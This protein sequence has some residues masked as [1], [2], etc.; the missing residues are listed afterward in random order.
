MPRQAGRPSRVVWLAHL[1]L[2]SWLIRV[3]NAVLLAPTHAG[4]DS[5]GDLPAGVEDDPFFQQE[6][7]PF[8][9]PFFQV[10]RKKLD[11]WVGRGRWWM[12]E[13]FVA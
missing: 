3:R 9:D 12:W 13:L 1:A 4:S 10:S 2:D 6:E 5:D 7:N 11:S 8:N